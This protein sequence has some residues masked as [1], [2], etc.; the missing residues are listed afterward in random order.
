MPTSGGYGTWFSSDAMAL[1]TDENRVEVPYVFAMV[2]YG[3]DCKSLGDALNAAD[4][5][6][7]LRT[8]M[9]TSTLNKTAYD[10]G[11]T[12][13]QGNLGNA[14]AQNIGK[15]NFYPVYNAITVN[16]GTASGTEGESGYSY[17]VTNATVTTA[18]QLVQGRRRRAGFSDRNAGRRIHG[19]RRGRDRGCQR[20]HGARNAQRQHVF[21]YHA[22]RRRFGGSHNEC[23]KSH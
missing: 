8:Y 23:F 2:G 6:M 20:R 1:M 21:L 5:L 10:G 14:S 22:G 16:N 15:I 19:Q 9:G 4:T 12:D 7:S 3:G 18:G 11:D 13:F 17:G